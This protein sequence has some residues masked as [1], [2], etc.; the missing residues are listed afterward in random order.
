MTRRNRFLCQVANTLLRVGQ[1]LLSGA[2]HVPPCF[3]FVS[4][5]LIFFPPVAKADD[6]TYWQDIRPILRKNCTVCHNVKNL[7]EYDVSGGLAL[8][9]YEGVL[10]GKHGRVVHPKHSKDSLLVKMITATDESKRMPRSSPPLTP[11]TIA[12]I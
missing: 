6:P 7:K 1:T 2:Q 9:S 5:W 4:F 3:L 10:K 8:D 12:L 11:E